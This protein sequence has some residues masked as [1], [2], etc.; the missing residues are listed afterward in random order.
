MWLVQVELPWACF[1]F[2][3]TSDGWIIEAAPIA[4]WTVGR[5]GRQVVA[6]YRSRGG[7]VSWELV[8]HRLSCA[9]HPLT[10]SVEELH[11][12]VDALD[13]DTVPESYCQKVI[14]SRAGH[15]RGT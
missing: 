6:Y 13:T 9:G 4:A 8:S 5:R 10:G 12:A 2:E 1:G 15:S 14:A 3:V 11:A 7:R